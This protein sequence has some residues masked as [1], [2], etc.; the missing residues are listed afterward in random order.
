MLVQRVE[1]TSHRQILAAGMAS[2]APEGLKA[3]DVMGLL[4][5]AN[6]RSTGTRW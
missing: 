1:A 4:G 2:V 6:G 3:T 5:P